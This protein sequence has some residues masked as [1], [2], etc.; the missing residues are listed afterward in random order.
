MCDLLQITNFENKPS[1]IA[2]NSDMLIHFLFH[3]INTDKE[4]F[5]Q[6]CIRQT[7]SENLMPSLTND[8]DIISI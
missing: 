4:S 3:W 2:I 6:S 5:R 8:I 7:K 1:N